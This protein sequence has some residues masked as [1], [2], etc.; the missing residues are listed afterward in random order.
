MLRHQVAASRDIADRKPLDKEMIMRIRERTKGDER[1]HAI[2][3]DANAVD[4]LTGE[5][6]LQGSEYGFG[7]LLELPLCGLFGSAGGTALAAAQR[8]APVVYS[9][10]KVAHGLIDRCCG[11]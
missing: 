11:T 9:L 1:E 2:G 6:R 4:C 10:G 7:Q 8:I 5:P 3:G